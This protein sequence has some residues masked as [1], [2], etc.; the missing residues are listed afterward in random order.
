[1]S[2]AKAKKLRALNPVQWSCHTPNLLT[3]ALCNPGMY[4]LNVPFNIFG[5]M[6]AEVADRA[7]LIDDPE[8][9]IL[10]LRLTLYSVADMDEDPSGKLR[11]EAFESQYKRLE[12]EDGK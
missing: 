7:I 6:L 2:K 4:A 5:K 9:N 1:M 8:L 10:M 3:E 11:Q 12:K